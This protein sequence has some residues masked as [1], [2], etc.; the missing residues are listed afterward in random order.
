[1]TP[2]K[3]GCRKLLRRRGRLKTRRKRGQ[4]VGDDISIADVSSPAAAAIVAAKA[5]SGSGNGI[6]DDKS[7]ALRS[8]KKII[9]VKCT[10]R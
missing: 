9:S 2:S 8:P 6:V 10:Y 1:M 3:E 5:L 7:D 4:T